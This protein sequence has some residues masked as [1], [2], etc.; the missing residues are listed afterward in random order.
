ME[1]MRRNMVWDGWFHA[2]TWII[3]VLG[4]F[5]LRAEACDRP[6]REGA[7]ALGR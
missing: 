1:A 6:V 3:T 2:A 5:M 7:T 4:V